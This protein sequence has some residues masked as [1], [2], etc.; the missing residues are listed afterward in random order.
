MKT[1]LRRIVSSVKLNYEELATVLTQ[2]EACLNSRPLVVL[3]IEGEGIEILTPGHFLI[4][5]PIEAL[6]DPS[7]SYHSLSLLT[8]WNL[9]QALVRHFW[10]RWSSEYLNSL[11]RFSKWHQSA[12]SI[13][14]GDIVTLREDNLTPP[15]WPLGRI[16]ETHP[17][18]DGHVRVVTVK[19]ANGSYKRPITK[20]APLLPSSS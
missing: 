14:V 17:G 10:K 19:T 11:R 1:H 18:R 3:P 5:R 6:P 16:I 15:K 13:R 20:I 7:C 12:G 9:C 8:R 2:V 4:G